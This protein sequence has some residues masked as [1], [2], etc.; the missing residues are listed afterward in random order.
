[1]K[2]AAK[3]D[4]SAYA[5]IMAQSQEFAGRYVSKLPP[6]FYPSP[7]RLPERRSGRIS[8]R[9]RPVPVGT[10]LSIVSQR[11]AIMTGRLP[12]VAVIGKPGFI[13]HEL[14]DDDRGLWMT[15]LPSELNEAHEALHLVPPRG[16]ALIA[17]LGLGIIA[18][19]IRMTSGVSATTT[20]ERNPDVVKLC[21]HP[22]LGVVEDTIQN[23]VA[24]TK[25][26]YHCVYLDVWQSQSESEFWDLVF[27]LKRLVRNRF[28]DVPIWCWK[29]DGFMS[30]GYRSLRLTQGQHWFHTKLPTPL[31][32]EE[33][34]FFLEKVG[35]PDWEKQYGR[36]VKKR[37]RE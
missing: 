22:I 5:T 13:I 28:G 1:M 4:T 2:T 23:Y 31:S 34:C 7:V 33:A 30:Q 36:L 20:V 24:T 18:R 8:I 35:L 27:P 11:D 21:G 37:S 15:D 26:E 25:R 29:E 17:G 14:H 12:A 19:M 6:A 9:H 10:R 3:K 32:H 16:R